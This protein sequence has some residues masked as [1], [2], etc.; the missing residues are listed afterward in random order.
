MIA[1]A[2]I[3]LVVDTKASQTQVQLPVEEKPVGPDLGIDDF[4]SRIL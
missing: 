1:G 2:Q 3:G 4:L